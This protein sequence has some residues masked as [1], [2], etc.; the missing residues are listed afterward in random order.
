MSAIE[1]KDTLIPADDK[2]PLKALATAAA[3]GEAEAQF[4]LGY[5]YLLGQDIARDER[6]A[7]TLWRKSAGQG[8]AASFNN[9]GCLHAAGR[10]MAQDDQMAFAC[11]QKAAT[12]DNEIGQLNLGRM[13]LTGR[14]TPQ[15]LAKAKL[16]LG[17]AARHGNLEA[18]ALLKEAGVGTGRQHVLVNVAICALLLVWSALY[19]AVFATPL[20]HMLAHMPEWPRVIIQALPVWL[21]LLTLLAYFW[22]RFG[23]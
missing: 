19:L 9:L 12:L 11:F 8:H 18:L 2:R 5:R 6:R 22:R 20:G 23:R 7:Y 13:Y 15:N 10:A 21:P 4:G 3:A 16:W 14:G 17:L 1:G